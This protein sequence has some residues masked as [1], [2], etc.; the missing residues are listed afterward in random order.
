MTASSTL[1]TLPPTCPKCGSS[2]TIDEE[3]E[4]E[5]TMFRVNPGGMPYLEPER[6]SV[7]VAFCNGCEFLI[8]LE[9]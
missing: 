1:L 4:T 5:V 6:R 3:A 7:K 8:V 2:F 9:D